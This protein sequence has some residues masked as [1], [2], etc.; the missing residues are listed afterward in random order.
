[1][2]RE[3]IDILLDLDFPDALQLDQDRERLVY[4]V[5]QECLRNLVR[6]A[7]PCRATVSLYRHEAAIV[8]EIVDD[9][10]GFDPAT[11]DARPHGGHFGVR[12]MADAATAAGAVLQ[13][14][15]APGAGARWRLTVPVD[16]PGG[17][18]R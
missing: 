1:M 2:R 8:L 13:V 6:H 12:A 15:S 14:A 11:L 17:A 10:G 18:S 16:G 3:G 7:G 9:G 4:R 5:A